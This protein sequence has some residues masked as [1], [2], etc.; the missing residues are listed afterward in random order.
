MH[1][2]RNDNAAA[3]CNRVLARREVRY[4]Y[5]FQRVPRLSS[6]ELSATQAVAQVRGC[7]HS[8]QESEAILVGVRVAMSKVERVVIVLCT[9][10]YPLQRVKNYLLRKKRFLLRNVV[11][12]V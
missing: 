6:A 12:D 3:L 9:L 8:S 7:T 1:A 4:D 11:A 5:H 2:T 10:P